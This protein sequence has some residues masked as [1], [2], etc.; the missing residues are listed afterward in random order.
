MTYEALFEPITI[1]DVEIKN[2][3]A[4]APMNMVYSD[5][6][7]YNSEQWL[8]WYAA[9]A[10]GGFGLIITDCVVVNPYYWRGSDHVNPH[11]FTDERHGRGLGV[12][13][14]HIHAFGAKVFIQLSPGFG[15]QGH[16]SSASLHE[17][18]AAP[19]AIPIRIDL[20]NLNKGWVKQVKRISPELAPAIGALDAQR[21]MSD[22]QY[23]R[24]EEVLVEAVS[25]TDP[26]LIKVIFGEV[27]RELTIAEIV[28]LEEKMAEM[29]AEA[30]RYGFDG[31]EI[32][33]PHGYL[34][35]QFLSPWT[36]DRS[37]RWGD[38]TRFLADCLGAV[39]ERCGEDFP[40]LVKLSAADDNE[41]GITVA[42]MVRTAGV[43]DRLGVEAAEISYGTMEYALNII[44]GAFPVA[45]V[46]AANPL[47]N[48]YPAPVRWAVKRFGLPRHAGRFKRFERNYNVP[49]ALAVRE[50]TRLPVIPVGGIRTLSEMRELV[51][52]LGFAAVGLSRPLV[53]EPDL[54]RKLAAGTVQ[55]SQCSQCNL[56]TV[57][58]DGGEPLRCRRAE[59]EKH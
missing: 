14:D 13:A 5:P 44:R 30:L 12:L 52:G 19:S 25:K 38:P 29:S 8:A 23:A 7:G 4:M 3:I 37:D 32:H 24:L 6:E 21:A 16:A 49:A 43:L 39:R 35:H 2:R 22:E 41:P 50:A 56:C 15:R 1:G 46:P 11:L 18:P 33:S 28:F 57:H 47:L 42:A 40:V 20:R 55:A 59:K 17:A 34:I 45:E 26:Q 54:P 58:A 10:K 31:V 9:R 27:P 48:R 51:T 36:N 53:C